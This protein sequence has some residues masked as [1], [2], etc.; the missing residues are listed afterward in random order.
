MNQENINKARLAIKYGKKDSNPVCIILMGFPGTGKSYTSHYLNEKY[1][2]TILSGENITHAIFGTEKCTGPQYTEAY[3]VL[4]F[5]AN[6]LIKEGYQIVIDGTNLKKAF[7]TSIYDSIGKTGVEIS[8]IYLYIDDEIALNRANSRGVDSSNP[9]K[10]LSSCSKETFSGFKELLEMPSKD[11]NF[12]LIK[13]DE[14]LLKSLDNFIL[15]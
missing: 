7:R 4:N 15:K 10:I 14:N 9:T 11:E 2:Y 13:S 12:Y 1:G 3:S 6:E 8:G 5:L